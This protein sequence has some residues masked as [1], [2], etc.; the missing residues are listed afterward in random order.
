[1][2]IVSPVRIDRTGSAVNNDIASEKLISGS[3]ATQLWNAFSDSTEQFHV[4]QWSSDVCK[5][6]V[7][8]SENELCVLLEGSATLESDTGE[9]WSYHQGDAFVI[10]AGF[11]GTWESATPVRKIYAAFEA[12]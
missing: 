6:Q 11:V 9:T 1:M 4:G 2:K 10:P 12:G 3:A 7:N 8:Y 5:L